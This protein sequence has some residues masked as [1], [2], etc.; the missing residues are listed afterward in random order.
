MS[1]SFPYVTGVAATPE[2][3][4]NDPVLSPPVLPSMADPY[5]QATT[6]ATAAPAAVD[7]AAVIADGPRPT[8]PGAVARVLL[9]GDDGTPDAEWA[10]L[11][12]PRLLRARDRK[13]V[14]GNI[15]AGQ[16]AGQSIVSVTDGSVALIIVGW[17]L[18]YA[19][20]S[21]NLDSLGDLTMEQENALQ[22]HPL[23]LKTV[24]MVSGRGADPTEVS[25]DPQSPSQPA[26]G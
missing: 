24:Q 11:S 19:L 18:P 9:P 2:Q 10:D 20:P 12:D 21:Q 17:S 23:V 5:P 26:R 8:T 6:V 22:A 14:I 4:A 1:E 15:D 13:R 7:V 3:I 25:R 16:R